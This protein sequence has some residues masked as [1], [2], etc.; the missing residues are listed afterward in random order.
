MLPYFKRAETLGG[1]RRTQWRGGD[2]PLGTEIGR[3]TD[4]MF[5]AWIEAGRAAGHPV[6][7]DYNGAQRVGFGARTV[8]DPRR[9]AVIRVDA[10]ISAP[11]RGRKNLTV[12]TRAHVARVSIESSRA[13]GVEIREADR[14]SVIRA[15]RARSF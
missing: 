11:C 6:T 2:G 4:P 9:P 1:R 7:D 8:H 10:P 14:P 13:C 15:D 5:S 3:T 12:G